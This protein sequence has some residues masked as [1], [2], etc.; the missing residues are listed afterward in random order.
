MSGKDD[1]DDY[2]YHIVHDSL[3]VSH[4]MRRR[5][6]LHSAIRR[7]DCDWRYRNASMVAA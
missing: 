3:G 7:T 6:G 5:K 4:V 1:S 2:E